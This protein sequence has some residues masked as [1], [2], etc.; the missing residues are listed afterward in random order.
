MHAILITGGNSESRDR[1]LKELLTGLAAGPF[2]TF[3]CTG[4]KSSVGIGEVREFTRRLYLAPV[5]PG[6]TA[7]V[8]RTGD[9]LTAEA[10]NALLKTL[11]E[12]PGSVSIIIC[13]QTEDRLLPTVRSR[14]R[15][16]RL[17][18]PK[19][20]ESLS[21]KPLPGV[22]GSS[23][24]GGLLALIDSEISTR[25]EAR[26]FIVRAIKGYRLQYRKM[27]AA[28]ASGNQLGETIRTVRKLQTALLMLEANVSSKA[29]AESAFLWPDLLDKEPGVM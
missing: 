8:I 29:A 5:G 20:Q 2:N 11:E 28:G 18:A 7:G 19:G 13:A 17:P 23:G 15:I 12:P 21:G 6:T 4:E 26:D 25:E 14:C 3:E 27:S 9:L 10:Q 22:T 1:R 24:K 16:I